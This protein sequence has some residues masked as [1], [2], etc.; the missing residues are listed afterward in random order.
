MNVNVRY[1]AKWQREDFSYYAW[2]EC[3]KLINVKSGKEVKKK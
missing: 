1:V 2:T 3:N